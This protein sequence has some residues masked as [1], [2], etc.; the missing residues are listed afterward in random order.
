MAGETKGEGYMAKGEGY[1][2]PPAT[3]TIWKSGYYLEGWR[4]WRIFSQK[5]YEEWEHAEHVVQFVST[6]WI[7]SIYI[8]SKKYI[9]CASKDRSLNFVTYIFKDRKI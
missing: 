6:Y 5:K 8:F 1:L 2:H 3:I 7:K 9:L 4:M